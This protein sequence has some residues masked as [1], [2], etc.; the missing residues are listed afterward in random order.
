MK[1]LIAII[2]VL[3]FVNPIL[4][5]GFAGSAP[6][7]NPATGNYYDVIA[8]SFTWDQA[9]ADAEQRT[10]KGY[11]GHLATITSAAENT[12][13]SVNVS[14]PDYAWLGGFQSSN[15]TAPDTDWHWVTGEPFA[16]TSWAAGEPS[17]TDNIYGNV[18]DPSPFFED[19]DENVLHYWSPALD[20]NDASTFCCGWSYVIEYEA[21]PAPAIPEP[22]PATLCSD[23]NFENPGEIRSNFTNDIDR[24]Q[25]FCRLIAANGNYMYW[26]G[27]PISNA[28]NIGDQTI[29]DFGLI[30]AVDVFSMK[31][32]AGFVGDVDI[33]LKGKGYMIYMNVGGSPRQPQLWS[34]WTSESFTGYT[35]T[36]LYAPGT[37]ALVSRKPE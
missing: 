37:V 13:I 4:T 35:C 32:A 25:L 27:S 14:P 2:V 8:G 31:G 9:K 7:F 36:T 16:Y 18:P 33:C 30:A 1:S 15:A 26:F 24:D 17:D 10:Y 23:T 20:W 34:A 5:S 12:F 3:L 19:N 6:K 22:P 28:G 11:K 29:L 21:P